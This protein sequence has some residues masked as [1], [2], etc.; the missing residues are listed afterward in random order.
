V[1]LSRKGT[2][3]RTQG[4][5]FRSTGT[6]AKTR[7][8]LSDKPQA[9]LIA[10]L[11]AHARELEKKLKTRT[12]ELSEALEQQ[13]A[14]S[15]VLR[16]ISSSPGEL[17]PV[18]E[19]I[20]ANATRICG[21]TFGV[22]SIREGEDAFRSVA[23]Y[24][25]PQRYVEERRRF[26]AVR[27]GPETGLGRLVRTKQ[28]VQIEDLRADPK[29]TI[30]LVKFA[31][32]RTW[33]AVPML[34]DGEVTGS[35]N[36]YR[37]EVRPFTAKQIGLVQNFAA[38]AI[39]AIE[40]TRLLNE[41]RESLQQQTA[42]ADVLKVISRSTFDLQAVLDTLV[43]SAAR[44]CGAEMASISRP[45][46]GVLSR[47]ASYGFPAELKEYFAGRPME[48]RGTLTGRTLLER[49]IIHIHDVMADPEYTSEAPRIA[50]F[51]TMLGVPLLR[52]GVPIG[53]IILTRRA[54]QPFT[55]KQIELV[56]TFAD[57]A[58][59]AIE[60]VRLFD[61]IQEK[62]RQLAEASEHKSQFRPYFSMSLRTL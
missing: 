17:E 57:Q 21:A 5:K 41:L 42:T 50:G 31:G 34:K 33:L 28:V 12:R 29:A 55:D 2:K 46:E 56:T 8:A 32:A 49:K 35:I 3:D 62:N 19:T 24:N 27:Y 16:I 20:L 61:E 59:I 11:K 25:A 40:N 30:F 51:R 48:G 44:L 18:F 13:T 54:L 4:R 39:I 10:K 9:A 6:K 7:V 37:Q 36:I 15:E 26:G 52:E 22:L 53:V 58:V 47:V 1:T 45:I 38:Q 60:N 14:S 23:M 43:E